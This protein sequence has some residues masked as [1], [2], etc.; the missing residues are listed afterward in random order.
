LVV[1]MRTGVVLAGGKSSRMG[2]NKALINLNG[3]PMISY[4]IDAMLDLVDEVVI[5]VAKGSSADYD[6]FSEIGFEVVEDSQEGFG[7]LEGLTCALKSARGEYVLISPCDTPFLKRELCDALISRAD[8][9]DGAV[10]VIKGL[11][12]PL[13]GAFRRTA[14]ISA[15]EKATVQGKRKPVDAFE[16]LDL[17]VME[18][19][20]LRTIDPELESFWNLNGPEDV[21]QAVEKLRETVRRQTA[22]EEP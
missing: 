12:E 1:R 5:S 6:E 7:P 21:R 16:G 2:Q 13:H 8:G 20:E 9:R 18:E 22:V 10:P 4:V 11:Y 14:A 19:N 15:F 17:V 3:D